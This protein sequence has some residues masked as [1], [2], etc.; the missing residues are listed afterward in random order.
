MPDVIF[1]EGD[2]WA[3]LGEVLRVA[4]PL[5]LGALALS[6][7][8]VGMA[9]RP[10]ARMRV[11]LVESRRQLLLVGAAIPLGAFAAFLVVYWAI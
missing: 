4:S 10:P 1:S 7:L 3:E 9:I 2:H 11:M 6:V 5:L 8:I